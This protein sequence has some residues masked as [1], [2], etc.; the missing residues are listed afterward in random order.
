[1]YYHVD[2]SGSFPSG[3]TPE[4]VDAALRHSYIH[5]RELYVHRT[6]ISSFQRPI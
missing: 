4:A 2:A 1:M 6:Q 5:L 3:A